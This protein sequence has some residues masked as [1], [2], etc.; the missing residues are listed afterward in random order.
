VTIAQHFEL[1]IIK[2]D[3][4]RYFKKCASEGCP[5]RVRAVKLFHAPT[6]TIKSLE[7]THTCGRNEQIRL[8]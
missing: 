6:F 7:G 3:M 2:S 1:Y 5:W 4:I 8:L